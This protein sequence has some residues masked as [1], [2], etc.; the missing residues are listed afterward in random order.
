MEPGV[1]ITVMKFVVPLVGWK[2]PEAG[3]TAVHPLSLHQATYV[4]Y[5]SFVLHEPPFVAP[6]VFE[7]A[8]LGSE[9]RKSF[10]TA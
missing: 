1:T 8:A 10:F 7:G 2:S 4:R 5:V 9:M 6:A 3:D